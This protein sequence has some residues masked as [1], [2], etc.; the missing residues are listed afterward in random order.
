VCRYYKAE[1]EYRRRIQIAYDYINKNMTP[2]KKVRRNK[3]G[4]YPCPTLMLLLV[5]YSNTALVPACPD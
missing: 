2:S 3:K 4:E 5:D 1:L